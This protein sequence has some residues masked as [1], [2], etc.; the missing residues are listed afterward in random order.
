MLLLGSNQPCIWWYGSHSGRID[1]P[2]NHYAGSAF[3]SDMRLRLNWRQAPDDD[4]L[5][6]PPEL[7]FDREIIASAFRRQ[8]GN[9]VGLGDAIKA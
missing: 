1:G 7:D 2:R 9:D 4:K 3:Q 5:R 8:H 6:P